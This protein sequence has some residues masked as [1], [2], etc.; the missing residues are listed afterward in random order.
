MGEIRVFLL[1][2]IEYN[3]AFFVPP[4]EMAET[5]LAGDSTPSVSV[6]RNYISHW[7]AGVENAHLLVFEQ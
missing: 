4:D 6:Q 2:A 7:N 3:L 5:Q 1:A